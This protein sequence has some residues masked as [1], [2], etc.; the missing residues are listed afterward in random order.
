[1]NTR[2]AIGP[3]TLGRRLLVSIALV[4]LAAAVTAW[5]VATLVGPALF[6][7]HLLQ[8]GVQDHEL[9]D[10]HIEEA[11]Q[12]ASTI[13]LAL[14]I[15]V[16][17]VTALAVSVLL[18]RRI[19]RSV[20]QMSRAAAQIGAGRFDARVP[21]PGIGTE[22][23]T[24]AAAFNT[25]AAHLEDDARLRERLIADVA[26]EL[27][28]PAATIA[29]YIEAIEDG[30]RVLD[31]ETVAVLHDQAQRLNRLARDLAAV[32]RA[33]SGE[34]DLQLADVPASDLLDAA[35]L[36]GRE[37]ADT[38]G[39]SIEVQA[40][41]G[42]GTVR[43]DRVRLAQVLD[44]LV[45]NAVRH[46]PAGG[47][48]TLRAAPSAPDTVELTVA[49]TGEGIPAEH[50]EHVFERFYRVDS[51]RDRGRGGSGVGLAICR[52]LVH[53]HHGSIRA[54]SDGTGH[55]STFIVRLP[56]APRNTTP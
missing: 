33:E 29:A 44:N 36:A 16:A 2:D 47:T 55:G 9:A 19:G 13:A 17:G 31:T 41:P 32:T 37:R 39:V 21:L 43:V 45:V 51:A 14:A 10:L 12:S 22:F 35:A 30:V 49:D 34:L 46:T 26:H 54:T 56:A 20:A 27:R 24:L 23:D 7:E 52:A 53:A 3:G 50:L 6:H 1:M 48:I 18:T 15:V 5:I 38:A 4:L 28:T 25:M 11:F 42:A 8:A 40:A